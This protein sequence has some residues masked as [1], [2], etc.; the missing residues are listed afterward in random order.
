MSADTIPLT[1]PD[2]IERIEQLFDCRDGPYQG[3][4][5]HK[6]LPYSY[7]TLGWIGVS[8]KQHSDEE[9]IYRLRGALFDQLFDIAAPFGPL[10][11]KPVLYWRYHSSERISEESIKRR[12]YSNHKIRTRVAIPA[13]GLLTCA[14]PEGGNYP[15][16]KL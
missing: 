15:R 4:V 14:I 11:E 16:I 13:A 1:M 7:V 8:D 5:V 6:G 9:V 2:L 10:G 12:K 3:F